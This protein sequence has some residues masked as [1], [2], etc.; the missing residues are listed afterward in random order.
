MKR[1]IDYKVSGGKL[2]R[3]HVEI[4]DETIHSIKIAGDFFV[5]PESA[6]TQIEQLLVG[7][8]IDDIVDSVNTFIKKNN[9]RLIGFDA[10]DLADAVRVAE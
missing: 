4:E 8:K 1:D 6:I 3:L 5:H 7:V 10:S 9:I 2:L